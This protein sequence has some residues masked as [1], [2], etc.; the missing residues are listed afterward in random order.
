MTHRTDGRMREENRERER[1]TDNCANR[2]KKWGIREKTW[3][4]LITVYANIG[5]AVIGLSSSNI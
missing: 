2:K 1:K 5:L 4:P 3:K